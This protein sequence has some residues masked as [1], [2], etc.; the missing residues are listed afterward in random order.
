MN[1]WWI[2]DDF[3]MIKWWFCDDFVMINWGGYSCEVLKKLNLI[4]WGLQV[5]YKYVAGYLRVLNTYEFVLSTPKVSWSSWRIT[6]TTV[7]TSR[8]DGFSSYT[9]L[10][11]DFTH[12]GLHPK[13]YYEVFNRIVLIFIYI[14]WHRFGWQIFIFDLDTI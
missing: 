7:H 9:V 8:G 2:T 3:V 1:T 10:F 14:T 13:T 12:L 11:E 4:F 5:C 6:N